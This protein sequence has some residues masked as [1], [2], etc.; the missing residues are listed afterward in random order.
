MAKA[1]TTTTRAG[2]SRRPGQAGALHPEIPKT[3][4]KSKAIPLPEVVDQSILAELFGISTRAIRGLAKDGTLRRMERG[5]YGFA[6]SVQAYCAR[7]RDTAAGRGGES[8]TNTLTAERA[9]LAR[10][11]AEGQ[12][13]KNAALRRDL[14]PAADV[15]REWSDVLRTVR[16][17]VLAVP[18]RVQQ[19]LPHLSA[20][21]VA[22]IDREVR[23]ALT[24]VA[25]GNTP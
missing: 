22:E 7:L 3:A 12:A 9:R 8:A 5:A 16:A 6:E 25:G 13:M 23:A 17:G 20:H 18:S 11:Q 4:E 2:P 19:R 15:E 10:E 24:Q 1:K 21:D 14:V